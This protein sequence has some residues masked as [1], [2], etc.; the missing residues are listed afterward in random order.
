MN[1]NTAK[2]NAALW[3]AVVFILGAAL[4]G[5][6]GYIFG[7]RN[8][9]VAAP[10]PPPPPNEAERRARRLDQLTHDLGLSDAQRQQMDTLL[11]QTHNE[12]QAIRQRNS[13]Q[14]ES[15]MD[16]ERQKSR[17]QIRAIL[18]AEQKPKFEEFLRRIDE[19]RKKN[20]P[21]LGAS[22]QGAPPSSH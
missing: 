20:A 19:E 15:D 2:R 11:L 18:S 10:A 8:T 6:F 5:V 9:V 12:F 14:L 16:Q 21:P 22:P 17:D 1:E 13:R 3:V 7:H 4:G